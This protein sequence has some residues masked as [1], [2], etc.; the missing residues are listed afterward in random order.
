[1]LAQVQDS[2]PIVN[3]Y[4]TSDGEHVLY[5]R[6]DQDGLVVMRVSRDGGQPQRLFE[7]GRRM[8]VTPSPD[9]KRAALMVQTNEAEIWVMENLKEA[10][11]GIR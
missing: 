1:M 7:S 6:G 8:N 11:N 2:T 9:R 4:F 3:A 5:H 10:L